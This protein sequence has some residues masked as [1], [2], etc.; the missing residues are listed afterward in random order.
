M[1]DKTAV[2]AA[3]ERCVCQGEGYIAELSGNVKY[4]IASH[5]MPLNSEL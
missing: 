1:V 3:S 2:A 5:R 4:R